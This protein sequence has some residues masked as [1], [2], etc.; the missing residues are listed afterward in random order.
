MLT[1]QISQKLKHFSIQRHNSARDRPQ[2]AS[3]PARQLT[4]SQSINDTDIETTSVIITNIIFYMFFLLLFS[5]FSPMHKK[6][7]IK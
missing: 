6:Q 3:M 1:I 5:N 2:I 4:T 7:V